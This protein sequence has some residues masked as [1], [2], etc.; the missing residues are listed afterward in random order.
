MYTL[1]YLGYGSF[2][3]NNPIPDDEDDNYQSWHIN[4]NPISI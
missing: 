4:F 1:D 2:R 3:R